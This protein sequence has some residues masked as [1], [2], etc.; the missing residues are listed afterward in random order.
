ML[1]GHAQ[2]FCQHC[3]QLRDVA[4]AGGSEELGWGLWARL[5]TPVPGLRAECVE[6]FVFISIY[7]RWE[8][9]GG[10]C[11]G[12]EVLCCSSPLL[13]V[14]DEAPDS[15]EAVLSSVGLP[16]LRQGCRGC[17]GDRGRGHFGLWKERVTHLLAGVQ[18]PCQ[19]CVKSP[20]RG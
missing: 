5:P 19:G 14:L 4:G 6:E 20:G 16:G 10:L 18:L 13:L 1:Q 2:A 7:C 12:S 9:R 17:E 15:R 8:C 3:S 11:R